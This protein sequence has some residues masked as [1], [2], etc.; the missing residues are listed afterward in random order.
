[1]T[2]VHGGPSSQGGREPCPHRIIDDFGS[3]FAMG[4]IGGSIWHFVKGAKNS[5]KGAR[6]R[7]ALDAVKLRAPVLGGS[8]A[9]WG[10]LFSSFDCVLQGVRGKEDPWNTIASGAT[11]GAVLAMRSGVRSSMKAAA[12]GGI[13]L[14]LIE[15]MGMLLSRQLSDQI[16]GQ[17][18]MTPEEQRKLAEEMQQ[19]KE[20]GFPV[21]GLGSLFR[22]PQ[23][24]GLAS[25]GQFAADNEA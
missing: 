8:F 6:L 15:G 12:A 23:T 20:K 1:M 25:V 13:L 24:D 10:G 21:P 7:G 11:T 17:Q 14:A 18:M 16:T 19:E 2:N 3:A 22:G 9:V 5:P 4:A